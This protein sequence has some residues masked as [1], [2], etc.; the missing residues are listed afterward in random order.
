MI[1]IFVF[2]KKLGRLV[3]AR[4]DTWWPLSPCPSQIAKKLYSRLDNEGAIHAAS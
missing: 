3:F 2:F 1:A 4:F